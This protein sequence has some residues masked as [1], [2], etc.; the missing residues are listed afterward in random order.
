[1]WLYLPAVVVA[2]LVDERYGLQAVLR[3]GCTLNALGA[4][5]RYF[6][7][8]PGRN[9]FAFLF[10]GQAIAAFAQGFTL[11]LSARVAAEWF[12][13]KERALA[14]SLGVVSIQT[15]VC[16]G[17]LLPGLLVSQQAKDLSKLCLVE[18]GAAVLAAMLIW[19]AFRKSPASPASQ[20]SAVRAGRQPLHSAL[21][22]G[23]YVKSYLQAMVELVKGD[24]P[25]TCVLVSYGLSIGCSYSF[26][27]LINPILADK[28]AGDDQIISFA[29]V[30]L[31]LPGL[32]AMLLAGKLLDAHGH[33][34]A[35]LTAATAFNVAAY[36]LVT[37][38]LE[39]AKELPGWAVFCALACYGAANSTVLNVGFEVAAEMGYPA[40]ET[41]SGGLFN[42]SAQ[43]G[44]VMLI[45]I[46]D[47]LS[48]TVTVLGG[49]LILVGVQF[50]G[51]VLV[52]MT[53]VKA[54]RAELDAESVASAD[55]SP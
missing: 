3:L 5:L 27:T 45:A 38:V 7:A 34:K 28:F 10:T 35:T 31:V 42:V 36:V 33:F 9:S 30:A 32:P 50:A 46:L 53:K 16:L 41:T 18:A 8:L 22:P 21:Q 12:P 25:F 39:Q 51:F 48:G 1:M 6:A 17:M 13:S 54:K 2:G 49:N 15:G 19:L 14:T 4:A 47:A 44:G 40:T 26:A 55:P 29:G 24:R 43:L 52:S 11:S 23:A 20:S 37:V